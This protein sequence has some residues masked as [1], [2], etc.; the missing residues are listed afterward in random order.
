L[1]L[2]GT[3]LDSHPFK[4]FPE[5]HQNHQF[6]PNLKNLRIDS[7][8]HFSLLESLFFTETTPT[9]TTMSTYVFATLPE[10]DVEIVMPYRKVQNESSE[11]S[12]DESVV[13]SEHECSCGNQ[14]DCV[15]DQDNERENGS[16]TS[17][18][19]YSDSACGCG[20][21]D[22]KR[23]CTNM[24]VMN[25]NAEHDEAV[26]K[27]AEKSSESSTEVVYINRK[28]VPLTKLPAED[29]ESDWEYLGRSKAQVQRG[30]EIT[31]KRQRMLLEVHKQELEIKE[32]ER[33]FQIDEAM[34]IWDAQVVELRQLYRNMVAAKHPVVL[35]LECPIDDDED[36]I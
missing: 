23:S 19:E 1:N 28:K 25:G 3:I 11:E 8:I 32:C 4:I 12:S 13:I 30:R 10:I 5:F 35:D 16:E 27:N 22:W 33:E 21:G 24:H 34:R 14:C 9:P 26:R 17:D 31:E 18:G 2:N 36:D 29:S 7:K 15:C 6:G 20:C